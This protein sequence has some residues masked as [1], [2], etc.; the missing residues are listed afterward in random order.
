MIFF[1]N[2]WD[3]FVQ[4]APWLLLGYLI[5]GLLNVYFP[6]SWMRSH[7]GEASFG[8]S[9]KAAVIGAPLP[10]CSCGVI[11]TALGLRK[12]GASKNATASFMVFT[13]VRICSSSS[14]LMVK[15]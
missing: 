6:K 4:S 13:A 1:G 12:S 7:L 5:A 15:G 3:L 2:L 8:H 14:L 9:V 11:P 10:L